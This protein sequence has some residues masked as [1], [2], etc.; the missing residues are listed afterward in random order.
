MIE[1][2][3]CFM[4]SAFFGSAVKLTHCVGW[5]QS[6]YSGLQ[7]ANLPLGDDSMCKV[8]QCIGDLS[9]ELVHRRPNFWALAALMGNPPTQYRLIE[10]F[11]KEMLT[12]G[13]LISLSLEGSTEK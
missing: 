2:S 6:S 9:R 3:L 13:V 5:L 10:R 7:S 8:L 1:A 11:A 4:G 12:I